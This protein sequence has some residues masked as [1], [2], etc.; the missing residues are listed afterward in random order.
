M[1]PQVDTLELNVIREEGVPS[2]FSTPVPLIV[3]NEL[4][5]VAYKVAPSA[6]L[7]VPP[8]TVIWLKYFVPAGISKVPELIDPVYGSE[9]ELPDPVI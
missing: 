6:T 4:V 9:D 7:S 1:R 8:D 3:I 2:A 5:A